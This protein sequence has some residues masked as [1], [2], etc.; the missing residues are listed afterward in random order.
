MA[1]LQARARG[2]VGQPSHG[3]ARAD[4]KEAR[5]CVCTGPG[6]VGKE[7]AGGRVLGQL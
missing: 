6:N 2:E 3:G 4:G 7:G 5:G 1:V